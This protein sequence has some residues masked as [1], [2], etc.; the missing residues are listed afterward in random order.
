MKTKLVLIAII[1]LLSFTAKSQ[2][3]TPS[4]VSSSGGFYS[5][6]SGMLS[7]TVAEMTMVQTFSSINNMLTQ[8]FQQPEDLTTGVNEQVAESGDISLYPNPSNGNFV[9]SYTNNDNSEVLIRIYNLAGQV[10]L[11][12]QASQSIGSNKVNFDISNFNQG[13]YILELTT[14]NANGEKKSGYHKIS[15][16]Y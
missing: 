13:M 3:L 12:K 15:L 4:V 1:G 7:F 11:E 10:V 14:T 16:V 9:L 8:G 6:G 2:T 5:N